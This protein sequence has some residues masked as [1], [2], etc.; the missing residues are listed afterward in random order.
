MNGIVYVAWGQ[1]HIAEAQRSAASVSAEWPTCLITDE[2]GRNSTGFTSTIMTDFHDFVGFHQYFRK[3]SCLR[4]SPF[5]ASLYLDSDTIV[6]GSLRLVFDSITRFGLALTHAPGQTLH[7]GE[8]E[9]IHLN[10][11]VIG[12]SGHQPDL[13]A[14]ILRV[15]QKIESG[16]IGDEAAISIAIQQCRIPHVT[17]PGI[18]NVHR[19]GPLND[20]SIR[21]FHSRYHCDSMEISSDQY[22]NEIPIVC[23]IDN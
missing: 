19:T 16:H 14:R 22:G 18:F 23:R 9:Y 2:D 11:G 7:S 5:S 6:M 3:L 1:K 8:K 17:L 12:F 10:G 4:L 15:S 20:R 21:I 13:A